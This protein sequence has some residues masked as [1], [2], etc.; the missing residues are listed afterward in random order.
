LEKAVISRL[1]EGAIDGGTLRGVEFRLVSGLLLARVQMA[2]K[3]VPDTTF[4]TWSLVAYWQRILLRW[5]IS[6]IL[7]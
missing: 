4:Q 7:L 2:R 6:V 5:S 3:Y 1:A